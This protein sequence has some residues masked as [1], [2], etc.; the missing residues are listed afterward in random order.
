MKLDVIVLC[1]TTAEP[2]D[3]MALA[4]VLLAN[5]A[6]LHSV[7]GLAVDDIGGQYW[8]AMASSPSF[9]GWLEPSRALGSAQS[10][11]AG[12]VSMLSDCSETL[13]LVVSLTSVD[14][15]A[16]MEFALGRES[17]RGVATLMLPAS[18]SNR[19]HSPGHDDILVVCLGEGARVIDQRAPSLNTSRETLVSLAVALIDGKAPQSLGDE[20]GVWRGIALGD[21]PVL[22]PGLDLELS[23]VVP[24]LDASSDRFQRLRRSLYEHTDVPFELIAVDNGKS[25]RGFT[26]PVNSGVRACSARY[27]AIINDDVEVTHGWWHPLKDAMQT[28]AWV[29]FPTTLGFMRTDFA[30]RCFVLDRASMSEYAYSES[31]LFD[32]AFKIWFQDSDLYLRLVR[33]GKPPVMVESSY[34]RHELSV[35]VNTTSPQLRP[36]IDHVID[37]DQRRFLDKWGSDA[38]DEV[39]FAAPGN[40][41]AANSG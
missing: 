41:T 30:A 17:T 7:R 16:C 26:G 39:G 20:D 38:L 13:V 23:I 12:L 5:K 25:P 2:A 27:V 35:T 29:V 15:Q 21:A 37:E 4:G 9:D 14:Y 3:V 19:A 18:R 22:E 34:I 6:Q 11:L 32:P 33:R 31:D 10:A 40:E 8:D 24:T 1:D 28:G 36:W